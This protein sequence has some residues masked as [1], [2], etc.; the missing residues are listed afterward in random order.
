VNVSEYSDPDVGLRK[1]QYA[2]RYRTN[3]NVILFVNMPHRIYI[4]IYMCVC[5][6]TFYDYVIIN[7]QYLR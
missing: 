3:L 1:L 4:Y 7:Y 5:S 6:N 2:T